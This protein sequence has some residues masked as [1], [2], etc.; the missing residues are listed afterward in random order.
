MQRRDFLKAGL[1]AAIAGP[2]LLQPWQAHGDPPAGGA[3]ADEGMPL[4]PQQPLVRSKLDP[5]LDLTDAV[6]LET[7]VKAAP[8]E[9]GGGR[10]LDKLIAGTSEGFTLDTYPGN[11]LRMI[12]RKGSCSFDARLAADRWTHVAGVY[13]ASGKM[14][15][16]YLDGQQVA[17]VMDGDFPAMTTPRTPLTIGADPDG[18]NLFHGRILRA[19]VYSRALTSEEIAQRFANPNTRLTGAVGE[20][21]FPANPGKTI[22]PIHGALILMNTNWTPDVV[23]AVAG[24]ENA[25][26]LWYRKPARE[27]LEA[28]PIGNGRIAAMVFG[29]VGTETL[30]L[31]EGTLWGGGPHNYDNP[32]G[33]AAL[34]QIRQLVFEDKFHE[35]EELVNAK[36]MGKPAGQMPYQTVGNLKL[37]FA[38]QENASEYRRDLDVSSARTHVQY[39]AGGVQYQREAFASAPDNVIVMRLTAS[40]PGKIGFSVAFD[41]PQKTTSSSPDAH[42]IAIDGTSGDHG[43]VAG[44]VKF[45]ALARVLAEGGRVHSEAGTL[46]VE[47]ANAVTLLISIATS[48]KNYQDVSGDAAALALGY[49][50]AAAKKPYERIRSAHVDDYQRMFRRVEIDLGTS[51]AAKLPTDERVVA[52]QNGQDPSLTALHFQFGRYLLISC[53][54]PGNQPATLQGLWNHEMNPPWD[55]KYTININTEMNYWPAAPANLIECYEP[56]FDMIG[57]ISVTGRHTAKTQYNA[58]G[59]V[60]HHNTDAWRGTA[61]VD[62]VYSGMWPSGGM[63]L[64]KSFWDHYEFTGDEAA[65]RRHYPIMKGAA[66]FFLDT[67]VEHPVQQY[68]VTNP[69]VS[70]EIPHAGGYI[71][72][73]PTMDNQLLRDLFDACVAAAEL[74]GE[75]ADFAARVKATRARLAPDRVGKAG[76]LRE[77]LD[78]WD[79]ESPDM[80][81]RHVSHLYGLFPSHQITRRGTPELFAAASKSLEIRGDDATGWSM[82]WKINLWAR[83]EDGDHA[84]KLLAMLLTPQRTAPN[85]FDL[86]PP[87]QIDGNF[88]AV[89]GICEMLLQSHSQEIHLLPALPS[90][91]PTG[92]IHGLRARPGAE[93]DL[94]W[95]NGKLASATIRSQHAGALRIRSAAPLSVTEHGRP[96]ASSQDGDVIIFTAAKGG[97]YAVRPA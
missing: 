36:F 72:A 43:G 56:L 30:Q 60:T 41:S 97:T 78:D 5:A 16:L 90:A 74:F 84:H 10:I 48:Y 92:R 15:A 52:F 76:Q 85:L 51:P 23:G 61:P 4:G 46:T 38:D 28:L 35:A 26:A 62:Q 75:D 71:C 66:E 37:T 8:M 25:L 58:N 47:G 64:C 80:H 88:G 11:S 32:E 54:R 63:W 24:P 14:F 21:T 1:G 87:F 89:S 55:S 6:T 44:A 70:P 81:N 53:S 7:W 91:W 18:A 20:W 96:V 22:A 79:M 42:T 59:W 77:W 50:D 94:S 83:L 33:L 39:R 69:S 93:I 27:W 34:P 57:E 31:N 13:S 95:N 82:G 3:A 49:L 67:L 17:A 2:L 19:A 45:Q 68:L 29:G 40:K 12:T 9:Q 73:G 86:H 65:L